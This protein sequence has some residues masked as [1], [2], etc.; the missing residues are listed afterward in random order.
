LVPL[1]EPARDLDVERNDITP[2]QLPRFAEPKG[3]HALAWGQP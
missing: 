1:I 2:E 3:G